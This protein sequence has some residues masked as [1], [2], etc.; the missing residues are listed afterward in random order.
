MKFADFSVLYLIIHML[1]YG[2]NITIIK[3]NFI[4]GLNNTVWKLTK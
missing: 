1:V 4:T 2:H 3:R